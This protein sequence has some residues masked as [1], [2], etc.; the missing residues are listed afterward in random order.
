MANDSQPCTTEIL[1]IGN[2]H[3]TAIEAALTPELRQRIV[4]INLAVH[5]D[6]V[7]RRNKLLPP[8]MTQLFQPRRIFCTF[9]GSEHSVFGLLESP[10]RF[11]FATATQ[12]EMDPQRTPVLAGLIRETLL[13]AMAPTALNNSREL[14]RLYDCPITHLCTPPPFRQLGERSVLPRVFQENLHLGISPP[15]IRRKLHEIHSEIARTEHQALGI[16][17][18]Q[19]PAAAMDAEGYL[20][21]ECC[22]KDPTHAN[23]HYGSL[24]IQQMLEQAD[25]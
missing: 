1:V 5:F 11:D 15:Q 10:L 2:S 24:V 12:P 25:E 9:G 8:D 16:G 14:R 7:N 22:G 4:V 17:F 19:V 18:M 3:T 20:L 6:P 23:A 13:R 21:P